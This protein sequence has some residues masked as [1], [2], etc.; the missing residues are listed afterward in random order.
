LLEFLIIN[1]GGGGGGGGAQK[2]P[3]NLPEQTI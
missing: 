3:T 1:W 2:S